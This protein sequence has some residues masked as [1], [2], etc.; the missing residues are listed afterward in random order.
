MQRAQKDTEKPQKGT[1]RKM[2][3]VLG[4]GKLYIDPVT[5]KFFPFKREGEMI[6]KT[7]LNIRAQYGTTLK[8]KAYHRLMKEWFEKYNTPYIY[9]PSLQVRSQLTG[10]I[11]DYYRPDFL[12]FEKIPIEVKATRMTIKQDRDQ[13]YSYLRNSEFEV[14]YLFNFGTSKRYIKRVIYTNDRKPHLR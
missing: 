2:S 5:G 14:G 9:E 12:V 1:E 8:E 3:S 4:K 11:I 13:L 7:Y 6:C 10:K